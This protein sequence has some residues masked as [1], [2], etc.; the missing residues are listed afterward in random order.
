MSKLL[1]ICKKKIEQKDKETNYI[2][3]D[4]YLNTELKVVKKPYHNLRNWLK[5]IE[6][7]NNEMD[8]QCEIIYD[9]V[10]DFRDEELLT[11]YDV[12]LKPHSV[13]MK[14][15]DDNIGAIN[16]LASFILGL[17][18]IEQDDEKK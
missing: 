14:I 12:K 16:K 18:G 11:L 4:E 13:V 17:Y 9:Y 6:K 5:K 8:V 3:F 15:Y 2:Y 1:D 10:E 7:S